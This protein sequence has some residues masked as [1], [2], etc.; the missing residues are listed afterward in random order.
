MGSTRP[1]REDARARTA[2]LAAARRFV[3]ALGGYVATGVPLAPRGSTR[4]LPP[5]GRA[6]VAA[7]LELREALDAVI[8]TRRSYDAGQ[9]QR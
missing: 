3:A 2:Y 8:N 7:L 5:W 4:E 9:R 6:D 1:E